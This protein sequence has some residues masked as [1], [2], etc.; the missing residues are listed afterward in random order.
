MNTKIYLAALAPLA[1]AL[2]GC[3]GDAAEPTVDDTTTATQADA[4]VAYPEAPLDARGML[5]YQGTYS[6]NAADGTTRSITLGPD[7]TYTIANADGTN[8]T[9]TFNWYSDNSRILIKENGENQV[10]AVADGY[11]YRLADE[12]APLN[13]TVTA[14]MAYSRENTAATM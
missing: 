4:T 9:G 6:M 14:D 1:I 3:G 12:N 10:Y 5:D 11:L 13:G 8:S 7:D 2:A